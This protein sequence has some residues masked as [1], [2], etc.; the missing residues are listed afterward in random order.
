MVK[1][2]NTLKKPRRQERS[3]TK[4]KKRKTKSNPKPK[5]KSRGKGKGKGK[6]T[7]SLVARGKKLPLGVRK[8]SLKYKPSYV[9][10]EK[11]SEAVEHDN[12]ETSSSS[13]E[14]KLEPMEN[15]DLDDIEL[16]ERAEP[17]T[18][19]KPSFGNWRARRKETENKQN[20]E[21]DK[22]HGDSK[23]VLNVFNEV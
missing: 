2:K 13:D 12:K 1:Q 11:K 22:D 7:R 4:T 21:D 6:G 9:T 15:L 17:K 10:E 20:H 18:E 19:T 5:R 23:G 3:Q 14:L 8:R 16:E